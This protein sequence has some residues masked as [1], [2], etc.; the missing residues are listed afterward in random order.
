MTGSDRSRPG[1][2]DFKPANGFTTQ[3]DPRLDFTHMYFD[4]KIG[5]LHTAIPKDPN[6]RDQ[7]IATKV[8]KEIAESAMALDGPGLFHLN[9]RGLL[10]VGEKVKMLENGS[11]RVYLPRLPGGPEFGLA[12]GATTYEVLMNILRTDPDGPV[13]AGNKF[14]HVEVV[15][16]LPDTPKYPQVRI[17]NDLVGAR[18]TSSQLTQDS[19]LDHQ[20][21]F[22]FVKGSLAGNSMNAQIKYRQNSPGKV[23]ILDVANLIIA[24]T[25][26][27]VPT[28]GRECHGPNI[29]GQQNGFV[30]L[31]NNHDEMVRMAPLI[32]QIL[33][34]HDYI[35]TNAGRHYNQGYKG[36]TK[37]GSLKSLFQEKTPYGEDVTP[38]TRQEATQGVFPQKALWHASVSAF[39]SLVELRDGVATW[40]VPFKKVLSTYDEVAHRMVQK[41]RDLNEGESKFDRLGRR[42]PLWEA[43]YDLVKTAPSLG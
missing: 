6:P 28:G 27:I 19:D 39:R 32:P 8:A 23:R 26:G 15:A 20:G 22:D 17:V 31:Q 14:V 42:P 29:Y 7:N 24:L 41:A 35:G 21:L 16:G 25:P 9:N 33:E 30:L 37:A 38:F 4:T 12:D 43:L 18:N 11:L 13:V 2:V 34:L 36:K 40:R 1:Y 10:I 5:D 3:V